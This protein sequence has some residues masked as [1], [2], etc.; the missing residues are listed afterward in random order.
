MTT[1]TTQPAYPVPNRP[2]G[3]KFT[4]TNATADYVRVWITDA[5]VGS[6][7]RKELDDSGQ[8]RQQVHEGDNLSVWRPADI[9]K[10]GTYRLTVQEYTRGATTYGGAWLGDPNAAPSETKVGSEYNL[11]LYIGQRMVM[12]C[13]VGGD[14]ANLVLY[15]WNDTIRATDLSSHGEATPAIIEP[16]SPRAASAMAATAVRSALTALVD[17]TAATAIGTVSTVV[18]NIVTKWNAHLTQASVHQNNDSDNSIS[19]EYSQAPTPA[20]LADSVSYILNRVRRHYTNDGDFGPG[21]AGTDPTA[22]PPDTTTAPYHDVAGKGGAVFDYTNMPLFESVGDVG[23]AYRALADLFR[24]YEAHRVST[25]VHDAADSTN[26]LTALPVLL[27]VH[28]QFF[29][30][31][32]AISPTVP[33]TQSTAAVLLMAQAGAVETT[34]DEA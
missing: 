11:S 26:S 23:D 13:G 1:I 6:K 19:N 10:G 12:T 31:L 15:V 3:V 29:T 17:V 8:S 14:T 16:S 7:Y 4:K 28:Q 25:D 22:D 34:F 2:V 20:T 32:A 21:T 30:Q 18:S 24:S 33:D 9:D 27:A 5:P